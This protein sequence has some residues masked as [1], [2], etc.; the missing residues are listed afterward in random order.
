MIGAFI[1]DYLSSAEALATKPGNGVSDLSFYERRNSCTNLSAQLA[2]TAHSLVSGL[3][4]RE[5]LEHFALMHSF[6]YP[7]DANP[8]EKNVPD[9][10]RPNEDGSAAIRAIPIGLMKHMP[11]DWVLDQAKLAAICSHNSRRA[12]ESAQAVALTLH[13][14]LNEK[15]DLIRPELYDRFG[16]FIEMRY[17]F[18]HTKP[19]YSFRASYAVP[20]A[21]AIGMNASGF[22]DA[23]RE[24]AHIGGDTATMGII[25]GEIAAR[26]FGVADSYKSLTLAHLSEHANRILQTFS[27]FQKTFGLDEQL[28]CPS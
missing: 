23:L 19:S 1:G 27:N 25:A 10:C 11:L 26:R 24:T 22:E 8:W 28:Q 6:L 21:I 12:I 4:Y 5:S 16:Y 18:M 17:S 9:S 13:M 14:L 20:A 7:G 3:A 2:A 15:E